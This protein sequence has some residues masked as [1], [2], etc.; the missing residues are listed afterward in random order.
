MSIGNTSYLLRHD[1]AYVAKNL[2]NRAKGKNIPGTSMFGKH[3][4]PTEIF[5]DYHVSMHVGDIKTGKEWQ[6][7]GT[8][9]IIACPTFGTRKGTDKSARVSAT[10]MVSAMIKEGL[11]V[12]VAFPK[13]SKI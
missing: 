11:L 1:A 13:A 2:S 6:D 4:A 9:G 3:T 8:A 12:K 5:F 10:R 7:I